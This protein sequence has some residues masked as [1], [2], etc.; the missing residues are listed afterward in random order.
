M[1]NQELE[2]PQQ[3]M[4]R[5]V[6][7]AVMQYW[8]LLPV[9]PVAGALL[10][11]I[12]RP[13]SWSTAQKT[14]LAVAGAAAGLNILRWQLQ[15]FTTSR[16]NYQVL[17]HDGAFEIRRYPALVVAQTRVNLGFDQALN[18]GF[19]R[20]AGFIFGQ[21]MEHEQVAMTSPV[22]A[23]HELLDRGQTL[24][25][26]DNDAGYTVSFVMP[27]ERTVNDLPI[28]EDDRVT[29]RELQP[30]TVAALSFR[31]R[32]DGEHVKRA[33][34]RLM[35]EARNHGLEVHGEPAFAGYDA[36]STLPLLRRNEV[37]VE[38]AE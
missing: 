9:L 20:L 6:V 12:S 11:L 5:P 16:P 34:A 36:P 35:I 32:Y 26:P 25:E 38:V 7:S 14:V 13:K 15:R 1:E 30:R 3:L 4:Q 10:H 21:N 27:P 31:G 24:A 17:Q 22:V 33:S 19:A 8:P 2:A 23:Q 29:L 28:P 37:W 18:E